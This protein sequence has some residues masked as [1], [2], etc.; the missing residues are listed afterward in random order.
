MF[1]MSHGSEEDGGSRNA[2]FASFIGESV[3]GLLE[4]SRAEGKRMSVDLVPISRSDGVE[5][6]RRLGDDLGSDAI[7]RQDGYRDSHCGVDGT[8][9]IEGRL[10][11]PL[12][13]S[14]ENAKGV[15]CGVV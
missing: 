7:S 11:A 14:G 9:K 3:A 13:C 8:K 5:N 10:K 6:L 1:R 12:S 4:T 15:L 2:G